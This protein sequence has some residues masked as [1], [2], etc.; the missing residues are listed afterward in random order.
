MGSWTRYRPR[1]FWLFVSP[2]VLGFGL[3]TLAP[4]AFALWMSVTDYDGISP[5]TSYVGGRNFS[6]AVHDPQMWTSLRQT[7]LLMLIVVP[8]TV[9]FGLAL[10]IAVNQRI[11]GRGVYRAFAYLP[12][13]I[14]VVAG[15]LTFRLL[16]DHD[17]GAVNGMLQAAGLDPRQWLAGGNALVVLIA[18]MLW[19]A[20]AGMV[21]SL[22]ALQGVPTELTDAAMVDGA[23]AWR[24]LRWVTVPIIS[25]ILLF[26]VVTGVIASLQLFVPAVLLSSADSAGGIMPQIPPGLRVYLVYVYQQYFAAADFGYASA[27][28]WLLF[29]V[30]VLLTAAVFGASR[31]VVF[32]AAGGPDEERRR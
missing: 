4:M 13:V 29:V 2:W 15:S 5:T 17:A 3:L 30:I 23:G 28:L 26:Q 14:P 6:R 9:A 8:L 12:A 7:V 11:R 20:G 21:I 1:T 22:A 16:F 27:L 24:R 19:G 31:Q 25:P 18:F 10:A 32:Y